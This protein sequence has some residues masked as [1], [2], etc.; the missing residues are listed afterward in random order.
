MNGS[1]SAADGTA[2]IAG[3]CRS[4]PPCLPI[5]DII[6]GTVIRKECIRSRYTGRIIAINPAPLNPTGE[7]SSAMP[8]APNWFPFPQWYNRFSYSV[9]ERVQWMLLGGAR[10]W[11]P[12]LRQRASAVSWSPILHWMR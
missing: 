10:D 7:F 4:L 8:P 2:G 6:Q 12:G 11:T 5:S 1:N 9:I 3:Q